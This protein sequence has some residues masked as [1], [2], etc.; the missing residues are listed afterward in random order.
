MGGEGVE[1]HSQ[2]AEKLRIDEKK[3][4]IKEKKKN[5]N[6]AKVYTKVYN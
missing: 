5:T 6:W 1:K 4:I 2:R 3:L